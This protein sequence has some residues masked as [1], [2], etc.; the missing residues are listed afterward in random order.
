MRWWDELRYIARHF[1]RQRAEQ[2]LDDEIRLHLEL[3]TQQNIEDGMSPEE[4]R[5]AAERAFGSI[6]LAKEDSRAMWGLRLLETLWQDARFSV[7]RMFKSPGFSLV[8]IVSL[9]LGIGANTA[10]F[11][12][13]NTVFLRPLTV[14]PS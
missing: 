4:A 6:T 3:E 8:A 2:N 14:P 9:A 5:Y 1:D 12:L 10:I 7:R 11:S 13:V